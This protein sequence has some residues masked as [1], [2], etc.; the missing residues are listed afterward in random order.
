MPEPNLPLT[1]AA[2]LRASSWNAETWTFDLVLS[3]GAAVERGGFTEVLDIDGASWPDTIPLLDSH[4]QGSLDDNLGDVSNIRREGAEIVGTVRLSKHS[5]KAKRLAAELSDG[6]S[7]SA[8]IG[9]SVERWAE[10]KPA[11]KRTLTAKQWR[12]ME[13]SLVSVPADPSSKIRTSPMPEQIIETQPAVA[14]RAEINA[15]IRSAAKAAGLGQDF[16]DHHVDSESDIATVNADALA[17]LAARSTTAPSN[18]QV[19]V[20]HTDPSAIRSAMADALAHRLAPSACKL[21]GRATEYRGHALLDLV[22]DMAVARGERVNLRDRDGLLERAVGAHSTSDFPLLLADAANKALLSQYTV[23]TPTYRKWAIRKQFNDFKEHT[24]ARVGD[25]PAFTEIQEGGA[26]R[27]GTISE[28]AERINAREFTTGFALGRRAIIN[29]DLNAL[30]DFSSG[31][32]TRAAS[33]ENKWVYG[34]LKANPN[35][36]DGTAVF[37]ANHGNLAASGA[38]ID[39]TTVGAA[40]KALRAQKSLDGMVLNLQPAILVVGPAQEVAARQLLAS[41]NAT[42]PS[43]V[44]IWSGFAELVVDAEI[45]DNAWFLFA[46]P[47]AAPVMVFGYVQGANGPVIRSEK[48]FDTQAI[49]VAASLDFG[50]G[51]TDFRGAYRNAGA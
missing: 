26:V 20:D 14:T 25:F 4:R 49:K 18:I 47:S 45:T 40:V 34:T 7:F 10:S 3:A 31:I 41:I 36:R 22:G 24:F 50:W 35:L 1:R 13:A 32:A 17:R 6:R 28:S 11:G 43:D 38:G 37:H 2:P 23:A 42:K 30:S 51:F 16:I 21:E 39:G 12:I 19:G 5:E 8:S 46:S 9:Y 33:D 44:N 15:S 27:Y 48:D 29:D